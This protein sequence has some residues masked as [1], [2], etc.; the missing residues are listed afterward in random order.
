MEKIDWTYCTGLKILIVLAMLLHGTLVHAITCEECIERDKNIQLIKDKLAKKSTELKEAL[1]AKRFRKIRGL[2]KAILEL[3]K[4]Q[5]KLNKDRGDCQKACSP[6]VLK[7]NECN[8]LKEKIVKKE[9][10]DSLS[11]DEINEVD[12]MYQDL[13]RCNQQLQRIQT[14]RR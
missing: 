12:E 8:N 2:N 4:E 10:K 3:K 6:D 14:N 1:D 7:K 9:S 13:Q 5:I 11:K